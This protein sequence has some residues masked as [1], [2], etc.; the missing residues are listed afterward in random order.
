M[1][2]SSLFRAP[3]SAPCR[4]LRQLPKTMNECVVNTCNANAA[5]H[6]HLSAQQAWIQGFPN[7]YSPQGSL[8]TGETTGRARSTDSPSTE[9]N[10][11]SFGKFWVRPLDTYNVNS[12]WTEWWLLG[13]MYCPLSGL[14]WIVITGH[15]S[16]MCIYLFYYV[17]FI[18]FWL[19]WLRL[20]A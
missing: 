9:S 15:G 20:H 13:S 5:S 4:S 14:F 1:L 6:P 11:W 12:S 16:F 3:C 8:E 17:M 18:F 7:L 19:C 2:G 10:S